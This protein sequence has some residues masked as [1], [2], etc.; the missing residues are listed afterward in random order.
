M[1][2]QP[3]PAASGVSKPLPSSRGVER[4][5]IAIDGPSGAG[6]TTVARSLARRLGYVY[7]DTGAMYRSLALRV[8][9][10]GISPE[11]ELALNP[12]ALSLHIHFVTEGG[13]T[14][15][16]CEGEDITEAIRTP[17]ISRLAS[18]ISKQKGVRE[19]L[20]Q[21]QR[22]M[23]KEGGVVLEGRDIGTVVF[24]DADVKF[25]LDAESSERIRRRYDEMIEKGVK[26]DFKETQEELL[27]RD[28]NDTHRVHS[29]LKKAIDAVFIDSTHRSVE[30][31]V[32]EMVRVI[33]ERIKSDE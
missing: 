26:V 12:L 29:P 21:M 11:D 33:Q 3:L 20:V 14:R 13:Q 9:E 23:G 22:E 17:E 7:I 19:A 30:E 10:R 2:G 16:F 24:P 5:T 28:H 15:V 31:V 4:L 25:Y 1:R 32:E 8:Q 27:Q 18:S 6:K